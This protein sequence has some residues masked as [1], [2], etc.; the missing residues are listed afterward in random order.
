MI[1]RISRYGMFLEGSG[2]NCKGAFVSNMLCVPQLDKD[3]FFFQFADA[4]KVGQSFTRK[5]G[6]L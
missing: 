2:K 1:Y 6:K 4:P 5:L 3:L